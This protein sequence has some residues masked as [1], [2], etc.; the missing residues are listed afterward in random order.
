MDRSK[1]LRKAIYSIDETMKNKFPTKTTTD[2]LEDEIEYSKKLI[3]VIEKEEN[4][5][6]YPK[7]KERLSLLKETV[8][9]DIEQLR[10]SEDK[11]AKVGHKSTDSAFFGYKTHLAMGEERIITA[12]TI[13]TGEK[14]DGKQVQELIK[15][16]SRQVWELTQ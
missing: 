2:V 5:A 14:N 3:N 10:I 11:D 7:V 9:D 8:A 13:S 12:A 1:K 4:L 16:A 6:Q 15:K